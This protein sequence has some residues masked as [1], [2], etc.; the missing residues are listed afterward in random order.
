MAAEPEQRFQDARE[1]LDALR[2]V[3][4]PLPEAEFPV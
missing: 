2:A 4:L 3:E 1:L